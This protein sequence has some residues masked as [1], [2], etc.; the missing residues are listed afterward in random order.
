LDK[1]LELLP[2]SKGVSQKRTTSA[3]GIVERVNELISALKSSIVQLK[4]AISALDLALSCIKYL[5][6]VSRHGKS[7]L[8]TKKQVSFYKSSGNQGDFESNGKYV[9]SYNVACVDGH[10]VGGTQADGSLHPQVSGAIFV[11][12][13]APYSYE[14]TPSEE[15]INITGGNPLKDPVDITREELGKMNDK[16]YEE[17]LKRLPK[18][19][20]GTSF[21]CPTR[22][23]KD[24]LDEIIKAV[25]RNEGK[26][27]NQVSKEL[28]KNMK[29]LGIV[30]PKQGPPSY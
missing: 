16:E 8:M 4:R 18:E 19:I 25:K 17:Y 9:V 30:V 24:W 10:I 14:V 15:G 22:L 2:Y 29:T 7:P 11:N 28:Q 1:E 20:S 27:P 23:A 5:P 12:K 13:T 3:H 21:A 6:Q 26:L